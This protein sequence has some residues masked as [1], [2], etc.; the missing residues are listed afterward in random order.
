MDDKERLRV[1]VKGSGG[2]PGAHMWAD[3]VL[4]GLLMLV[5]IFGLLWTIVFPVVGMLYMLGYLT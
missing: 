2:S 4:L 5:C 1:F 3:V